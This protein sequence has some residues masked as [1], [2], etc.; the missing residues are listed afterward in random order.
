MHPPP[1]PPP[2]HIPMQKDHISM[3]KILQSMWEFGGWWKCLNNSACTKSISRQHVEAGHYMGEEEYGTVIN[4]TLLPATETRTLQGST[5]TF[6]STDLSL[7]SSTMAL[8]FLAGLGSEWDSFRDLVLFELRL[9]LGRFEER[10]LLRRRNLG[11]VVV[12]NLGQN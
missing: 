11:I 2:P 5:C 3:L 7:A 10:G 8:R 12:D 9:V 6:N 4:A 1:P